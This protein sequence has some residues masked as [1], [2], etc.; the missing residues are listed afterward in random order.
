MLD[1]EKRGIVFREARISFAFTAKLICAFVFACG[2]C[3]CSYD[4]AQLVNSDHIMPWISI[5][6]NRSSV[7]D[8][9]N[10]PEYNYNETTD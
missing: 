7:S 2:K 6:I 5:I 10:S 1:L 3:W 4:E 8:S 9:A